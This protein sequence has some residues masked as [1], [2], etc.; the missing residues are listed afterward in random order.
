MD[1]VMYESRRGK[2]QSGAYLFLPYGKARSLFTPNTKPRITMTTGPLV[3][4]KGSGAGG[5]ISFSQVHEV[6]SH[7]GVVS[8]KQRLSNMAGA[9]GESVSIT[10]F[11][12]I[13]QE[14]DKVSLHSSPHS[15]LL[16]HFTGSCYEA[17]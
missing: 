6:V 17:T 16:E 10:T 14:M 9:D 4:G 2:Q 1:L 11:T 12:D 7:V 3:S 5:Q 15:V 13:R 8:V